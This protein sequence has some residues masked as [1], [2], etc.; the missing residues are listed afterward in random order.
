MVKK[1]SIVLCVFVFLIGAGVFLYPSF[2][3]AAQKQ[4]AQAE[5]QRFEN[6]IQEQN[7]QAEAGAEEERIYTDLWEACCAYNRN[8]YL[9][10]QRNW[11][12]EN[13]KKP[14][15]NPADFGYTPTTG[16]RKWREVPQSIRHPVPEP[17]FS[18]ARM[19]VAIIVRMPKQNRRHKPHLNTS[20]PW[21]KEPEHNNSKEPFESPVSPRRRKNRR[22]R[23]AGNPFRRWRSQARPSGNLPS[24][25]ESRRR[26]QAGAR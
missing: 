11:T 24:L 19:P 5:I 16:C 22:K 3:T 18:T 9:T 14:A 4:T 1:I 6:A 25:Q 23:Q 20:V 12:E 17:Q 15:L 2:R 13:Q 7:E 26:G 8:L 21:A 10:K